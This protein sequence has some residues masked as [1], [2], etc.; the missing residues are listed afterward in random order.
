MRV[1]INAHLII[2]C[3]GATVRTLQ[4]LFPCGETLKIAKTTYS[5]RPCQMT[6]MLSTSFNKNTCL[7]TTAD[8]CIVIPTADCDVTEPPES[9]HSES[10]T[11]LIII[12]LGVVCVVTPLPPSLCVKLVRICRMRAK[13]TFLTN[14]CH[15][16]KTTWI[17]FIINCSPQLPRKKINI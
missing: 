12:Y 3:A 1:R 8:C 13:I 5:V 4:Q 10:L 9:P 17:C 16:K 15:S 2:L 7:F 6:S 14:K 11:R